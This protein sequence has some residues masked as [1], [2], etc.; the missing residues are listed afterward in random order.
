MYIFPSSLACSFQQTTFGVYGHTEIPCTV[1][2]EHIDAS[3]PPAGEPFK[4][5]ASTLD[6]QS[7]CGAPSGVELL[8]QRSLSRRIPGREVLTGLE[9]LNL[10]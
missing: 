8:E 3:G 5:T 6:S 2:T 9:R 10:T 4:K 7:E 1:L